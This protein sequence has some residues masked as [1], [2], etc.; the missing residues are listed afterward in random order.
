VRVADALLRQTI[1]MGGDGVLVAVTTQ[2]G[3]HVFAGDPED[4]RPFG[5]CGSGSTAET[6]QGKPSGGR[7]QA[8]IQQHGNPR[9][10]AMTPPGLQNTRATNPDSRHSRAIPHSVPTRSVAEAIPCKG[11]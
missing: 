3:A 10:Q 11:Q 8:A 7:Q 9:I 2:V 5:G 4:V 1:Q 6:E